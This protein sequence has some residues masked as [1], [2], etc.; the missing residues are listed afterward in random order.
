LGESN[1]RIVSAAYLARALYDQ[2]RYEEAEDYVRVSEALTPADD[3][4]ARTEW[5]PVKA[6]L[7]ARRG[8]MRAAEAVAREAVALAEPTDDLSNHAATLA[9][10]AEML[11]LDGRPD[12][13]RDYAQQAVELYERKGNLVLAARTKAMADLS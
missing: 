3:L 8:E 4:A 5:A 7:L 9:D 12:E 10:L 13:A 6:K 2:G 1:A 11:T